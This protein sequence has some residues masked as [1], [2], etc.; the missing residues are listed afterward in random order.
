[1]TKLVQKI[2]SITFRIFFVNVQNLPNCI[3]NLELKEAYRKK[4]QERVYFQAAARRMRLG[5][6]AR[7]TPYVGVQLFSF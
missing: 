2:Y 3:L 4:C 1:M 7:G 6:S 5:L